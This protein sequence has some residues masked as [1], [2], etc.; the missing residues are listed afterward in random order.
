MDSYHYLGAEIQ[1]V[2][3]GDS[4]RDAALDKPILF[5]YKDQK[6]TKLDVGE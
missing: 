6:L 2:D 3:V 5:Q 4:L 1:F